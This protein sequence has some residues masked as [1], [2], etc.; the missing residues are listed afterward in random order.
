MTTARKAFTD[1]STVTDDVRPCDGVIYL[2]NQATT[3]PDPQVVEAMAP[4]LGF[5]VNPHATEHAAGRAATAAVE[6]ARDRVASMLGCDG[7]ELTFTSGATEA[8]NIVLRGLLS[9]G[10][11]L[12]VSAIEHPSIAAVARALASQGVNVATVGVGADGV[13]DLDALEEAL[14]SGAALASVMQVN[15]EIGTVQPIADVAALCAQAGTALHSDMTQGAGRTPSPLRDRQVAYASLSAHKIHGPQGIGALYVRRGA[16]QPSPLAH[17]GGQERG[18]RPGT[19]PVA[20]CVGF[21]KACEIAA[22]RRDADH[23]HALS[24]QRSA[25]AVLSAVG[26][27]HVNGSL[28]DRVPHNLSL[29]FAGIE[30]DELLAML[31]G[32]A[33]STGSACSG[34]APGSS[35]TLQA[36]GLDPNAIAATVRMGFARDT[37]RE[38][39]VQATSAIVDAVAKLRNDRR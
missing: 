8:S 22:E 11:G 6:Q 21:G 27:W 24:L 7:T 37:V 20:A 1:G 23:A 12:I 15:N 35:P 31:P 38:D 28:D 13:L 34:G 30:A 9:R 19:V 25:L 10:D 4:W 18:L 5:A 14:G 36:L 29:T 2:D 26:G 16:R 17:G 33:L 3:R 39:V 32:L